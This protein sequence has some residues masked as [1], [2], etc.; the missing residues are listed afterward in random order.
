[1][2]CQ[3]LSRF[4]YM[5]MISQI[6][7]LC[8]GKCCPFTNYETSLLNE[9]YPMEER[10]ID[11]MST[12][13]SF[14][15]WSFSIP[16]WQ[17]KTYPQVEGQANYDRRLYQ[18]M[19]LLK[20]LDDD[21]I[22]MFMYGVLDEESDKV[23][24]RLRV[25]T[26]D[27][28]GW[29]GFNS[30]NFEYNPL[31]YEGT[32]ILTMITIE[33]KQVIFQTSN[34]VSNNNIGDILREMKKVKFIIGGTGYIDV[35]TVG[36]F[37]GRLSK[38]MQFTDYSEQKFE[39]VENNCKIPERVVGKQRV[40]L[41]P[42]VYI[43]K[44]DTQN[45]FDIEQVGKRFCISG[46]VKY[47]SIDAV[48]KIEYLLLRI[49]TNKNYGN[50]LYIGDEILKIT[51]MLDR[52]DPQYTEYIIESNHYSIPVKQQ[53]VQTNTKIFAWLF[54]DEEPIMYLDA[55]TSWHYIQFEYGRT[56]GPKTLLKIKYF[57]GNL[58]SDEAVFSD[59]TKAGLFINTK[60]YLIFGSDII[61]VRRIKAQVAK[62][63]FIYNY[64]Q[65][66]E[67]YY[68]CY[69][70]CAT[71]NGPQPNNCLTCSSESNRILLQDKHLCICNNGYLEKDK[72]CLPFTQIYPTLI[73]SD[74]KYDSLDQ[75]CQFG[76]FLLPTT[77][78]CIQCPQQ[79]TL[80]LLCVDC[81]FNPTTWYLKSICT[82]DL[83]TQQTSLDQGAYRKIQRNTTEYDLYS[84]N[85]D[86]NLQ[87]IQ[88]AQDFCNHEDNLQNCFLIPFQ[89]HLSYDLYVICKQNHYF[90]NHQ[91]TLSNPACIQSNFLSS[92]CLE[93]TKG[94]YLSRDQQC[95][96]CPNQCITCNFEDN[97]LK[98]LSC[99]QTYEPVGATCLKCGLNCSICQRQMNYLINEFFMQCLRCVDQNKYYLSLNGVDCIENTLENC[100][101]AYETTPGNKRINSLDYDFVPYYGEV[102]T[103][104]AKCHKFYC[105]NASSKTCELNEFFECEYCIITAIKY[106]CLFGPKS[107][108]YDL[109]DF[110]DIGPISFVEQ[111]SGY[112]HNCY[113]CM[114]GQMNQQ[115]NYQCII[116]EDGY[117][118]NKLTAQCEP[119]PQEL[120]CSKCFQQNKKSKDEWKTEIR[121]YYKVEIDDIFQAHSF[122]EYGTSPDNESY[123][124]VCINC[125]SG[126]EIQNNE[127]IPKCPD[128]CLECLIMD[129]KNICVKCPNTIKGRSYSLDNN[130]CIV[131]PINCSLCRQRD[132]NEIKLI[133][134][135]FNSQEFLY[136]S[137][138][139]LKGY[140]GAYDKHLG[141]Y[142]DCPQTQCLKRLDINLNLYC[143]I[144]KFNRALMDLDQE[145]QIIQFK[146]SNIL[147]ND[148]FS[149][150]SFKEFETQQFYL[151]ANQKV[152]QTIS[153]YIVSQETQL[154]IINGNKS[155]Q[156][157]F[158]QNIFS[159]I[160]V[161]LNIQGNGFTTFSYDKTISIINFKNVKFDGIK[162]N[163]IQVG[164]IKQLLF[165]SA[166]LQTIQ[167]I[168]II[169][170]SSIE[171]DKS[172]I[173]INNAEN[174][175]IDQ[176]ESSN[177]SIN[178]IDSFIRIQAIESELKIQLSNFLFKQSQ[179][180]NVILLYFHSNFETSIE[181]R[182][183]SIISNFTSAQLLNTQYGQ[184][185]MEDIQIQNSMI[186]LVENLFHLD[187]LT[188]I[189]INRFK[190]LSTIIT[191][192]TIFNLNQKS[193]ISDLKFNSNQLFNNSIVIWNQKI[194]VEQYTFD[195][196][197]FSLNSYDEYSKFILIKQNLS[198]N[199]EILLTEIQLLG[200]WLTSLSSIQQL[201]QQ[202]ISLIYVQIQQVQITSLK[203]ERGSGIKEFSFVEIDSL[204]ITDLFITQHS[205]YVFQGL[206]QFIDC[207]QKT[208]K[209]H[210]T[211][212]YFYDVKVLELNS[213]TIS[214]AESIDYPIINIQ[215]SISKVSNYNSLKL[216]DLNLNDNLLLITN[217]MK[218]ISLI[219][220]STQ[221]EF[222]IE[223]KNS[224]MKKNIMHQYQQNDLINSGL[225][226]NF[227]CSYC[228]VNIDNMIAESN[229]VTNSTDSIIYIKSKKI[230][231]K[232]SNFIQNCIFDYD[233]IQPYL[234]WGFQNNDEVFLEQIK[235]I[236]PIQVI[237]GNARLI[238]QDLEITSV[239]ITNSSGSGL[240]LRME[241]SAKIIITNS[242]FNFIS[243]HFQQENENGGAIYF[244]SSNSVSSTIT[245]K[246]ATVKNIFCRNKGGFIYLLNGEGKLQI[247]LINISLIDVF[248]SLGS[249]IYSEFSALSQQQQNFQI[250]Q[251]TIS[252]SLNGQLVFF[253]KF[254][255]LRESQIQALMYQRFLILL[256]NGNQIQLENIVVSDLNLESFLSLY[257]TKS[258]QISSIQISRSNFLH[259][260]IILN[261]MKQNSKLFF[262]KVSIQEITMLDMI[263]MESNCTKIFKKFDSQYKC[264]SEIKKSPSN[265]NFKY[266][267]SSLSNSYCMINQMKQ[268][269]K[270]QTFSVIDIQ[271]TY[272]NMSLSQVTLQQ[273]NCKQCQNGLINLNFKDSNSFLLIQSLKLKQNVCGQSS[274]INLIKPLSSLRLLQNVVTQVYEKYFDI[275][276]NDYYCKYNEAFEGTC[277]QVKNLKTLITKS[278]F[279]H[280]FANSSGGSISVIGNE[281]FYLVQSIIYN[282]TANY[283]GGLEIKDQMS[284]NLTQFGS[285]IANNK[286]QL[287]G[288]DSSQVPSQLSI[289]IN[290]KDV[291]PR[292]KVL[293]KEDLLIEQILIKPYKVFAN[294]YSEAFYVPNGQKISEY[295]YFDWSKG[296]YV[297]YNLHF[298]IVALDKL[299]QIQQ[300]LNNSYCEISG[301]L[302]KDFGENE[303][304]QNFTNK[305]R[306]EFNKTDY[307]LDDLIVY[308]DDQFNMTLQLQIFCNS[309]YIPIYNKNK[310]I[311]S[312][313]NNYNLR[314][315]IKTLPCQMGE[316]KSLVNSAC[317]PCDVE[318]GQFTLNINSNNCMYMDESTTSEIRSAQLK[319]KAGYWRPYFYTDHISECINLLENCLGG[320]KEGDTSCYKG[321]I[322]ALCEEC[323]LYN[324]RGDGQFSTSTKYSCG[325]CTEK[326]KNSLIITA[327]TI[328]TLISILISVRSTVE[329]LN[330]AAIKIRFS[331]IRAF[332]F[333]QEDQSGVLIKMLTNHLQILATITT[334]QLN[335]PNGVNDAIKASGN[336]MQTMAFSLDCFLIDMFDLNIHYSRIV[337]QIIM[338]FIYIFVFLGIYFIQLKIKKQQYHLSVITT[339]F[340]YMY[341]YLQPN[342]VG[343]LIQLISYRTISGYQWI[344]ANV[345]YRYDTWNHYKWLLGFCLPS[346]LVIAFMIPAIFY[347]AIY[348]NRHRL[349]DKKIRQQWGYLYHE[350]T[351]QVYF[352][353]IVKILEKELLII[354]LSYYDEQVIKKGILVLFVVYLYQELNLKFKPYSSSNLNRLDAY[355]ANVCAISIALGIGIYIDQQIGSLE[356]QIPYFITIT[357]LNIYYL[358]LVLKQLLK[359]YA[360]E[361]ELQLDKA[362]DFIRFKAPWLLRFKFFNKLMRNRQ[363]Q[364][365]DVIKKFHKIKEY[366]IKQAKQMILFKETLKSQQDSGPMS[367]QALDNQYSNAFLQYKTAN[368]LQNLK[369]EK[370]LNQDQQPSSKGEKHRLT[371]VYPLIQEENQ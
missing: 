13:Q 201:E 360:K 163:P 56:T 171:Q 236:F 70:T 191:Q 33:Q 353:E 302:L 228:S 345:A 130:Q 241:N 68:E 312:Y 125:I 276:I 202:E 46:W 116:C 196:F 242:I 263:E 211:S 365:A 75:R 363:Q 150:S 92:N 305:K 343:G 298:R 170:D 73:F 344:S 311:I 243:S 101:I 167:L 331:K 277:L 127:C 105:Y 86:N 15:F 47:D 325:S 200:N 313:H 59:D 322:G 113:L 50:N 233:I 371:R 273:I 134:P 232:N 181:L 84:I 154:C 208:I 71:C 30:Y 114:I 352:W 300:N 192:S 121:Q 370:L 80:D 85:Q 337:W 97:N 55:L 36:I 172:Q 27:S 23:I 303:F 223:I 282:N 107:F 3:N 119:C 270:Q 111:C 318:Q 285:L 144:N 351:T 266:D 316:I 323:D 193:Q 308:L 157:K 187:L 2:N 149:S 25:E 160:N 332:S 225:I 185:T 257:N 340:I 87:L 207:L 224:I 348:L 29:P 142:V 9:Y 217:Q 216:T 145:E 21:R 222:Q 281:I 35:F 38:L 18:L 162:L 103:E 197:Y 204:K 66:Q 194:S 261:N 364:R 229:L 146:Q 81:L 26:V 175:I 203:I 342:L 58:D 57:A 48:K 180:Q 10:I 297:P 40:D 124:V 117:F 166:F 246:N 268:L 328:W 148:L 262:N 336:P 183:F 34:Y 139:C 161:E 357:F 159:A 104:C 42:E 65:D 39:E 168:Q 78:N 215:T 205:A 153:I 226:F 255:L 12:S 299:N 186:S 214:N 83:I 140:T 327:I 244:D 53:N 330:M 91:C 106:Q 278:V 22:V 143:D 77:Q 45:I 354:F 292:T 275:R 151:L 291:L 334:F 99:P 198:P 293:E 11:E 138:Q 321:H 314:I 1:M 176:F 64:D 120:F 62:F 69:Y 96:Q 306:V 93:C 218:Q 63:Q 164:N 341:I 7:L 195:K 295:Q 235:E 284:Q 51:A 271:P 290:L 94:F 230:K 253:N 272:T 315:N 317:V 347:F 152:I 112:N 4:K 135:I 274:C 158:S 123:E 17:V 279:E 362:R 249:I 355:S 147:I 110:E 28:W 289:T 67:F 137:N 199:K 213:L 72:I 60:Y 346:F 234:V 95:E 122:I 280:N 44:G 74:I 366:L 5:I 20:C 49:T 326:S 250:N 259:T 129:N 256:I 260:I 309:I 221:L 165:H 131:C 32:W 310:E 369:D 209:Y 335:I 283:G 264:L 190:V 24:H 258:V 179:F 227:D 237:T 88:G 41:Y 287:F 361:L 108:K 350:Y 239:L 79:S 182:H 358:F 115:I 265:L 6:L 128:N 367:L 82:T 359:A 156:Q 118:A 248:A 169:Y 206:H 212:L 267:I 109:F 76:Y 90:S 184:L 339:T 188:K 8:V 173:I 155:I 100:E 269:Q 238:S 254:I 174:V 349:D 210:V 16:L 54:I 320:W 19:F 296:E 141:I 333:M 14:G 102:T 43:F 132:E 136:T 251:A 231:I 219:Q 247:S 52:L 245:I 220:L 307:N 126:Y 324:L 356:I 338:P 329:L 319:L 368:S 89:L 240:Y 177:L 286:A 133:N 288:N 301:R 37:R 31:E 61:N 304:T 294:E 252:N 189:V 98:C 178:N